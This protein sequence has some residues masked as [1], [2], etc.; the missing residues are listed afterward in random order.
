MFDKLEDLLVR[1]EEIMS[2]LSEPD[3]A[4]DANRFRKLM[5]E[6][7]DLTPI[8]EAYR[9]Y[10]KNKQAIEDALAML[11][12]ESAEDLK[13]LAKEEL[14]EA[15]ANV[16]ELE[17]K[18]KI[19]LLPKDPNDDKNVIVE[20]RAGA[21]GEEAALFAADND[22]RAFVN[23]AEIFSKQVKTRILGDNGTDVC[24]YK[25]DVDGE[26]V[27]QCKEP[28]DVE[29][30][31]A[32]GYDNLNCDALREKVTTAL[33]EV[34]D[35]A[36]ARAELPSGTYNLI[37]SGENA[38]EVLSYY[39]ARSSAGMVYPGY[40]TW[41][42]GTDVQ[43]EMKDGE[44]LNMTLRA[45]VPFSSEA[46]PMKDRSVIADGKVETLHGGARMS[47][48]LG[49]EPTGDYSAY[50]CENGSVSFEKMKKEPY[51]YAVT[52]SDFQM[53]TM[54][55]HFGGEIRLAYLF[56]GERVRIVTGGSVNGSINACSGGMKFTTERYDSKNYSGPFA[57]ML[58]GV[59]VAG[60]LA[61]QE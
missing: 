53:D 43:P 14:N 13:E 55:G 34:A 1:Y 2:E 31:H 39:I 33:R 40:S 6:Q 18:L 20:I 5:K 45:K 41:K 15:K 38:A 36:I 51:L 25:N 28:E 35:R 12:E 50:S 21:G 10:K 26:F 11:D 24:Y 22:P 58:P 37:L 61:E 16:A 32:F 49:I 56:D 46:I 52:F 48:Y 47:Y 8:V 9:E 19:L 42:V 44:R 60:S 7:S 29:V 57:V 23:S 30:Y 17:D 54:S 27:V 4:N 59:R 3:V